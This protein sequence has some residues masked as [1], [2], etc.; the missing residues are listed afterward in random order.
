MNIYEFMDY[1]PFLTF[2]I[3]CGIYY[4]L[5]AVFYKLPRAIMKHRNIAKYGYPPAHCDAEGNFKKENEDE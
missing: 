5:V 3:A 2:L 4:I 1:H